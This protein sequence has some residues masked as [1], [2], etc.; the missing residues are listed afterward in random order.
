MVHWHPTFTTTS[1]RRAWVQAL[2]GVAYF[3]VATLILL[4]SLSAFFWAKDS[5]DRRRDARAER[6]AIAALGLRQICDGRIERDCVRLAA[7]T[8]NV[9]VVS[10]PTSSGALVVSTGPPKPGA[11]LG[12]LPLPPRATRVRYAAFEQSWS[13]VDSLGW[14]LVTVPSSRPA[15]RYARMSPIAVDG[16]AVNLW[17]E[18]GYGCTCHPTVLDVWAEWH[19]G[20]HLY[21]AWFVL[22]PGQGPPAK[23]LNKLFPTLRYT[24]PR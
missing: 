1:E 14:A 11:T 2:R 6:A 10:A 9:P 4:G 12:F 7:T 19:H 23:F 8:V 15:P 21:A 24:P 5:W 17:I 22:G 13:S 18:R 16:V 3:C 20:K